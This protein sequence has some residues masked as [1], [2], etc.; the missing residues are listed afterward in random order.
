MCEAFAGGGAAMMKA[1]KVSGN[2]LKRSVLPYCKSDREQ[3]REGA[4][5]GYGCAFFHLTEKDDEALLLATQTIALPIEQAG[6][7]AVMAAA[8][9]IAADGGEPFAVQLS[10]T[11]PPETEEAQLK[12]LMKQ[13]QGACEAL[14]MQITGGHTEVLPLVRAPIVTATALGRGKYTPA[15]VPLTDRKKT[16][17]GLAIVMSKWMGL[18]GTAI[19]AAE[20]EEA[21]LTRYPQT[22]VSSAQGFLKYLPILPEAATA[23]K[24]GAC[25]VHAMRNGGV[26]GGLYTLSQRLSVGLSIDLKK[27]PVKQETIEICEFFDLN[28]YELLTGGSLLMVT[29]NGEYLTEELQKAGI[30]ATVIGM[31]TD[32]NDKL[33]HNGEEIRYLEPA[34]PDEIGKILLK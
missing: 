30:P 34:G 9:H 33:L 5:K 8:N 24:S 26:F 3:G 28:P 10:L 14:Q 4:P 15:P 19:L 7:Y 16:A 29:E 20:R 25:A 13:A 11:L 18:E 17:P 6:H 2:V 31:T 1:G 21:L 27:I 22:I 23:L 12:A 32:D